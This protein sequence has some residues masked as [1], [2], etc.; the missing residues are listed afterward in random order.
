MEKIDKETEKLFESIHSCFKS[1]TES[2]R[3]YYIK[4]GEE[5]EKWGN[6]S[7]PEFMFRMAQ[8]KATNSK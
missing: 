8:F 4:L 3:N 7:I 6:I 5:I 1:Q 2:E